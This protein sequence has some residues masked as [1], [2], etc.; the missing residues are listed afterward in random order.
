MI[1]YVKKLKESTK[2]LELISNYSKDTRYKSNMQKSIAFLYT[3]NEKVEFD[4]KN[5]I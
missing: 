2:K 3:S 5:T 1:I 4:I